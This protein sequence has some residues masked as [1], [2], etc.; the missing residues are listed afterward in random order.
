MR[1]TMV[2][3]LLAGCVPKARHEL[4]EVQLDATRKA[5]V[6]RERDQLAELQQAQAE[7]EALRREIVERQV[8][9]DALSLRLEGLQA[10]LRDAAATEAEHVALDLLGAS[11]RECPAAGETSDPEEL[12]RLR[13]HVNRSIAE[14]TDA[15]AAARRRATRAAERDARHAAVVSAF[16]PLVDEGL[17]EVV[18]VDGSSVARLLVAKLYNE[19]RTTLSPLGEALIARVG[20]A[21]KSLPDHGLRVHG[22]TDASPQHSTTYASNWE[23][24]FAY[25]M[26]VIR[27]LEEQ[28]V[29]QVPVAASLAGTD[30][31]A[32]DDTAEGRRLNRRVELWLMPDP[33]VLRRFPA[34]EPDREPVPVPTPEVPPSEPE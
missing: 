18:R 11:L 29:P 25:A 7:I 21:L 1:W 33:A 15:V 10:E 4:V 8:Q 16:A 9:L 13:E 6:T 23:L 28:G 30:P 2:G 20:D 5:L 31:V 12:A 22:H 24:G 14:M 34:N 3:L 26:G 32:D 27:G 17:V 19:N